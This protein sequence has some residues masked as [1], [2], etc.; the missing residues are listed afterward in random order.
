MFH[1]LFLRSWS[2]ETLWRA[3]EELPESRHSS[4]WNHLRSPYTSQSKLQHDA[5]FCWFRALLPHSP[6]NTHG[7]PR[8]LAMTASRLQLLKGTSTGPGPPRARPNRR[9]SLRASRDRSASKRPGTVDAEDQ[10]FE[11][12][13]VQGL[14]ETVKS[15]SELRRGPWHLDGEGE[16]GATHARR[17][18]ASSLFR[19]M[20]KELKE[21]QWKAFFL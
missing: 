10:A 16:G 6:Q 12:A 7:Q 13:L 18:A 5:P 21:K 9:A 17:V 8:L 4:I 15:M 3:A 19:G 14:D 2:S 1:V 20:L 11:E